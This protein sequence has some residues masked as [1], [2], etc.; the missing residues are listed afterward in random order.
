[1]IGYG[2]IV[3]LFES[4][5]YFFGVEEGSVWS[6]AEVDWG[7]VEEVFDGV[8]VGWEGVVVIVDGLALEADVGGLFSE[9]EVLEVV[10]V[11][12]LGDEF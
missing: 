10:E 7:D 9:G 5:V 8:D 12:F 11:L 6:G 4:E 3:D 2:D 1:M